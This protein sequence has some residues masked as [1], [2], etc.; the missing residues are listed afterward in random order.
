ML[1]KLDV[2]YQKAF[3]ESE[4]LEPSAPPVEP[5]IDWNTQEPSTPPAMY[6]STL[7]TLLKK[8]ISKLTGSKPSIS[9]PVTRAEYIFPYKANYWAVKTKLLENRWK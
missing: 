4:K 7:T 8:M 2:T 6:T 9:S 3:A 5:P 1:D